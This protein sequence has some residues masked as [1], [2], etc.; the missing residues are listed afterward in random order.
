LAHSKDPLIFVWAEA[1]QEDTNTPTAS[2]D[3][4]LY[5]GKK[6]LFMA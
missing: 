3:F 2:P 1:Q 6:P 5:Y 4:S